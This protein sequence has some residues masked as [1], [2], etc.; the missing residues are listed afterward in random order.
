[1]KQLVELQGGRITVESVE[2]EGST[3]SVHI[4]YAIG[5]SEDIAGSARNHIITTHR[6]ALKNMSI[7][8]VE[9]NDIN[10]L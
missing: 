7:L 5:S 2:D 1:M 8:L 10:R 3:F 4:P 6:D 9:D